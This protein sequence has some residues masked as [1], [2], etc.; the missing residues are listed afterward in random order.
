MPSRP[1]GQSD[2]F[3]ASEDYHKNKNIQLSQ[4]KYAY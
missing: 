4:N 2:T 3:I 1:L